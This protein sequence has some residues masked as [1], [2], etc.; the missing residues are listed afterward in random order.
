VPFGVTQLVGTFGALC[1][2]C[3]GTEELA[4]PVSSAGWTIGTGEF[5]SSFQ[6]S[7]SSARGYPSLPDTR[8]LDGGD[9]T[10][11]GLLLEVSR[12]EPAVTGGVGSPGRE[13]AAGM[14]VAPTHNE[15]ITDRLGDQPHLAA[16][17][18]G[19]IE[20][21]WLKV[22]LPLGP[23]GSFEAAVDRPYFTEAD[24]F[25]V[26]NDLYFNSYKRNLLSDVRDVV[27]GYRLRGERWEAAVRGKW[28]SIS[29]GYGT[30]YAF[31]NTAGKA[32]GGEADGAIRFGSWRV[33][34]SV[35]FASGMLSTSGGFYPEFAPVSF[36][37]TYRRTSATLVVVRSWDRFSASLGFRGVR[38]QAPFW[39]AGGFTDSETY[40][41]DEGRRFRSVGEDLLA[42]ATI[43]WRLSPSLWAAFSAEYHGGSDATTLEPV[44]P[45]LSEVSF[46]ARRLGWSYILGLQVRLP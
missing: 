23:S 4:F 28:T 42:A 29:T 17:G 15:A 36:D 16:T 19:R 39:D 9:T 20:S 46:D 2:L 27:A 26:G 12:Q 22:R 38:T 18:N 21:L 31:L 33:A 6:R 45:G 7:I 3:P 30:A 5:Y 41:I 10:P 40:R 24:V 44:S 37:E 34:A 43:G 13:I 1:L 14:L 35:T 32:L 11:H 25:T 8:P